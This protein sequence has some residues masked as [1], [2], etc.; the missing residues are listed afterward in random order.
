MIS[1]TRVSLRAWHPS[2]DPFSGQE[3]VKALAADAARLVVAG[4]G[5]KWE[6]ARIVGCE[7]SLEAYKETEEPSEAYSKALHESLITFSKWLSTLS[8]SSIQ[9]LRSKG[10]N[11]DVF[12]DF[13]MD[14]N[15][16]E[17]ELPAELIAE[18]ARLRLPI[19]MIS[20]D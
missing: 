11:L 1:W 15:Q 6:T 4:S 12:I 19:N 5:Q 9:I 20:N 16:C 17:L 8:P 14:Q 18:V 10:M 7:L 2:G 3:L 13:W